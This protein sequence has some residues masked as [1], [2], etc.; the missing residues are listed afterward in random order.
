VCAREGDDA[1]LGRFE[2]VLRFTKG[3]RFFPMEAER[4][5][6]R[7]S[8]WV[9]RPN[10]P[11]RLVVASGELTPERLAE[12][13]RDGAAAIYYLRFVEPLSAAQ[14]LQNQGLLRPEFRPARGRLARVGLTGRLADVLFAGSLLLRGRVSG[15]TA[16]AAVLAYRALQEPAP[17]Y[18]Y[19][20]RVVRQNGYICLQYWFFY[21]MNDYRS[22]FNGVNDH[23]ADWELVCVYLD[24][25]SDAPL[26]VACSAHDTVGDDLRRRWDDPEVERVGDH[27][28]VYV[29]AGSHAGYFA[30]GEYLADIELTFL[31][32]LRRLWGYVLR[33]WWL[34][35]R[36]VRADLEEPRPRTLTVP[37]VDY[38]RG[39]GVAI[40]PGERLA[41]EARSLAPEPLWVAGYQGLWGL[42]TVDPIAGEDAPAGPKFNR[43]GSVRRS[44]HDPT[45][46]VG[47]DKVTPPGRAAAELA[48]A[49][50]TLV[51]ERRALE[52]AVQEK[53]VELRRLGMEAEALRAGAH[54]RRAYEERRRRVRALSEEVAALRSA[55]AN[56]EVVEAALDAHRGRLD[57]GDFGGSRAHLRRPRRPSA[58]QEVRLGRLAEGWAALSTGILLVGF[59]ALYLTTDFW[60]PGLLAVIGVMALM[61]ALFRRQV[62]RSA[63]LAVNALAIAAGLLVLYQL[64]WLVLIG[65][66]AV[67][68]LVII[69]D[70]VREL[71]G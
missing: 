10:E 32:P 66:V 46:W 54:Q 20:G 2:P 61:E 12:V 25:E 7:A 4:Y 47:L 16:A 67:A 68:S 21:A 52:L 63:R 56:A 23:E 65:L 36:Q 9:R 40:G 8:L 19:Y 60:L 48:L 58:A 64:Y 14:L 71:R 26:W 31:A 24:A 43:D 13:R 69:V 30:P 45:G 1:L 18:C 35:S 15:A 62:L 33:V 11:P 53:S 59:V 38:A 50:E 57:A 6:S 39:D 3:E 41:W 27:V 37:F 5:L 17:T 22:G 51:G 28:V 49:R 70:N 42:Y 34:L 44:W 29:G 55:L